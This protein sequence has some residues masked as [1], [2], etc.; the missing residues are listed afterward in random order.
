[1]RRDEEIFSANR[2]SVSSNKA[3]GK[4]LNST[5]RRIYIETSSTTTEMVMFAEIRTSRMKD[6]SGMIIVMMMPST[7]IGTPK[8]AL[9]PNWFRI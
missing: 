8:S 6:G 7:A 3:V 2:N 1:M 9:V 4:T 5:G